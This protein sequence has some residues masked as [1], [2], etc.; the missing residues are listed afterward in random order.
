MKLQ[1]GALSVKFGNRLHQSD[2]KR[3]IVKR[4]VH[5]GENCLGLY[6][7][8]DEGLAGM[9]KKILDFK[10]SYSVKT[11]IQNCKCFFI[12]VESNYSV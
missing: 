8:R 7:E 3:I 5:R 11:D 12:K 4:L 6:F 2:M 1:G 9:V 10:F